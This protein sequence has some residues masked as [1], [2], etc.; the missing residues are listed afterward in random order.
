MACLRYTVTQALTLLL[1]LQRTGLAGIVLKYSTA[2]TS[3]SSPA[4]RVVVPAD[5]LTHLPAGYLPGLAVQ[6]CPWSGLRSG[7]C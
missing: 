6:V 5:W 3:T 4:D 1:S 2:G 7:L